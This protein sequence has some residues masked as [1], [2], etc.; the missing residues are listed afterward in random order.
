LKYILGDSSKETIYIDE[1]GYISI[2]MGS[3]YIGEEAVNQ[4][5]DIIYKQ[6]NPLGYYWNEKDQRWYKSTGSGIVTDIEIESDSVEE[7][8]SEIVSEIPDGPSGSDTQAPEYSITIAT[9]GVK[10]HDIYNRD[11]GDTSS[12]F[13]ATIPTLNNALIEYLEDKKVYVDGKYLLGGSPYSC[14]SL[15]ISD[16][17]G[18]GYPELCFGI[19]YGS[20]AP[21]SRIVI[22]DY[23]TKV[24]IFTMESRGSNDY[25]LCLLDGVLHVKETMYLSLQVTRTG[26]LAYN[27]SEVTVIWDSEIN[28]NAD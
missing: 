22:V 11:D 19:S 8:V 6:G 24:T 4:I 26:V 15:Y 28:E 27:G 21:D 10:I 7:G 3:F 17:T 2:G 18:D 23:Q 13:T 5:F 1:N 9:D 25:Y 20:G 12:Y 14:I 16:L